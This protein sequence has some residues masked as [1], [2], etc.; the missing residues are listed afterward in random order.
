MHSVNLFLFLA[1][2]LCLAIGSEAFQAPKAHKPRRPPANPSTALRQ[3]PND[4]E[5]SENDDS[6]LKSTNFKD[7][8]DESSMEEK[9][10]EFLDSQFF[11]P[12][13][14]PEGSPLR[15]FADLVKNDY[16]T[17]EALYASLFIA[18]MVVISQELVRMQ[19]YG[20]Q[21]VPFQKLGNGLLF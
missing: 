10:N 15:W 17:A 4:D 8:T 6:G 18:G 2:F 9:M 16:A 19:M 11:D 20:D 13:Q 12:E 7:S 14:V 5:G 1:L 3:Q 21:Y